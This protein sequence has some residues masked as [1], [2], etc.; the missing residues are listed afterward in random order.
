MR[1]NLVQIGE[2]IK[3]VRGDRSG[4]AFGKIVGVSS[5]MISNYENGL[6]WPKAQTLARIIELSR[7]SADWLL[8]GQGGSTNEPEKKPEITY[9]LAET[10]KNALQTAESIIERFGLEKRFQVIE[11]HQPP[12][13]PETMTEDEQRLLKAFRKLDGRRQERLIEDAEDMVLARKES[14][15]NGHRGGESADM[16]CA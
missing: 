13:A 12:A 3:Q 14:H 2:R 10:E 6:A 11:I 8:Y 4:S 1:F 16:N 7:K 5:N 9:P 15:E